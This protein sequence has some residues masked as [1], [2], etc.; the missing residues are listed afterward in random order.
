MIRSI[1]KAFTILELIGRERELGIAEMIKELGWKK[2]TVHRIASTLEELGYLQQNSTTLK[3]RLSFKLFT[4]GNLT[5]TNLNLRDTALPFLQKLQRDTDESIYLGVMDRNE[6]LYVEH[7]P[8]HHILQPLVHVG[9][10][11][12]LHCTAIGKVLLSG[13]SAE[14]ARRLIRLS[15]LKKFTPNTITSARM[16]ARAT[17][18]I[19]RKGV[20]MDDEELHVGIRSIAAPIKDKMGK[21]IAGVSIAGP[22]VRLPMEKL[23][24]SLDLLKATA[25]SISIDL[26]PKACPNF[27]T[28]GK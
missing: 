6:V 24:G 16:L 12:P 8:S 26:K 13:L 28:K 27:A 9:S 2:S 21:V 19:R 25:E 5:K 20:A 10:R 23:K 11:A 1:G 22:T 15:D 14:D 4:L 18:E 3:Y 17:L 7:L